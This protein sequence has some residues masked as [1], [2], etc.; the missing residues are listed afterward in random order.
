MSNPKFAVGDLVAIW[1]L[2]HMIAIPQAAV[3]HFFGWYDKGE[4][5]SASRNWFASVAGYYYGADGKTMHEQHLRKIGP[6]EYTE[7]TQDI[8]KPVEVDA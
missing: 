8:H 1:S 4:C 5:I 2:K 7:D 6:G 3:S